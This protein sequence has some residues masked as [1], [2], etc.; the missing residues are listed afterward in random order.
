HHKE[1]YEAYPKTASKKI[2]FDGKDVC[3]N[4]ICFKFGRKHT[5][6]QCFSKINP[7]K[8]EELNKNGSHK[9]GTKPAGKPG[10][11][12][13]IKHT[14]TFREDSL[15]DTLGNT[16]VH[17]PNDIKDNDDAYDPSIYDFVSTGKK[18]T[19]PILINGMEFRALVD[20]GSTVSALNQALLESCEMSED[21][22]AAVLF[23]DKVYAVS[24]IS[25]NR[26]RLICNNHRVNERVRVMLLQDYDFLI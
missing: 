6:L 13:T 4:P 21:D 5:A 8:F 22:T 26:V 20:P 14:S 11:S 1:R 17:N 25:K 23:L 18:L 16:I 10:Q 3:Q 24:S 12:Y 2:S 9:S 7:S 19:L 15:S